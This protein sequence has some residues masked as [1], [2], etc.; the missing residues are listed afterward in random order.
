MRHR[1]VHGQTDRQIAMDSKRE[2]QKEMVR[3]FTGTRCPEDHDNHRDGRQEFF[4]PGSSTAG[5]QSIL[6]FD[7]LTH[8]QTCVTTHSSPGRVSPLQTVL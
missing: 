8:G 7:D 6:C 5:S 4:V 1:R 3:I 2:R